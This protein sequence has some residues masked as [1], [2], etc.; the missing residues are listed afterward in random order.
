MQDRILGKLDNI[1]PHHNAHVLYSCEPDFRAWGLA[2]EN[3][4][5][6]VPFICFKKSEQLLSIDSVQKS[7]T[8]PLLASIKISLKKKDA[9]DALD[10]YLHDLILSQFIETKLKRM[11]NQCFERRSCIFR[12]RL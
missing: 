6:D 1:S 2:L 5:G 9:I 7:N 11:E 3:N 8:P 12:W 4:D 10:L